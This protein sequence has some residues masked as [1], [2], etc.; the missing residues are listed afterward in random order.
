MQKIPNPTTTVLI[1]MSKTFLMSKDACLMST[2]MSRKIQSRILVGWRMTKHLVSISSLRLWLRV[3]RA[4]VKPK[5]LLVKSIAKRNRSETRSPGPK[6]KLSSRLSKLIKKTCQQSVSLG[7][8]NL[9]PNRQFGSKPRH[10]PWCFLRS[11]QKTRSSHL[12]ERLTA[13]IHQW[14]C[15]KFIA[16]SQN[17]S[18]R[19]QDKPRKK[20]K[21]K[22]KPSSTKAS[23]STNVIWGKKTNW[24]G[25]RN[26]SKILS[27]ERKRSRNQ[28][29]RLWI[30]KSKTQ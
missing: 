18:N 25:N 4:R 13:S 20:F 11:I 28:R 9:G 27:L 1:T 22:L 15:H 29:R 14:L 2:T 7:K 23:I 6:Y 26:L 12:K 10:L 5:N 8:A 3:W 16:R 17:L 30:W 19:N 21:T 24:T